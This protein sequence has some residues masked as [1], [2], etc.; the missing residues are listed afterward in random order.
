MLY[1][2][3]RLNEDGQWEGLCSTHDEDYAD[4]LVDFYCDKFPY[5]YID[6]LTYDE[7]HSGPVKWQAMAINA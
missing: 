3:C 7:Y 2:I 1:Y 6:V 4:Q 5:A